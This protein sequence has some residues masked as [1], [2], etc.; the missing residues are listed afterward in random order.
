MRVD[1]VQVKSKNSRPTPR[2]SRMWADLR[3]SRPESTTVITSGQSN[4]T[5]DRIAAADGRFNRIRQLAP[6]CSPT[7]AHWHHLANT[8]GFVL[9]SAHRVH[10]PSESTIDLFSRFC[11]AHGRRSLYFT[12]GALFP[13]IAPSHGGSWPPS[14]R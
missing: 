6:I 9:P 11:T 14:H 2:I 8:N 7:W 10:N 12:M 4:L 13:R 3:N 5:Q 1:Q